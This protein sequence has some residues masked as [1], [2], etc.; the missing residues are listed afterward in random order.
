MDNIQEIERLLRELL[1]SS[2]A[3]GERLR[4]I[5]QGVGVLNE[6]TR[7]LV[8]TDESILAIL[9]ESAP[10]T[11]IQIIQLSAAGAGG[12]KMATPGT[13]ITGVVVGA[14]GT[15]QYV[16]NGNI[17]GLPSWSADDPLVTFGASPDGDPT[18]TVASVPSTD[19]GA[20]FNLTVSILS[21]D[22]VTTLTDT[23]NVPILPAVT[24]PTGNA[25][26]VT[27]SQIL[28]VGLKSKAKK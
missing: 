5:D 28:P 1:E 19:T 23:A 7:N 2:L 8:L 18:K 24:P 3:N 10:A 12:S 21:G 9:Q 6:A 11:E 27:I 22:G 16:A 26:A 14:S 20:S 15:F 4:N 17:S 13:V 25:T